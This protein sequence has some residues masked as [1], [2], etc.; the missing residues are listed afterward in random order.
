MRAWKLIEAY[1]KKGGLC[2]SEP[3]MLLYKSES[4]FLDMA[5]QLHFGLQALPVVALFGS[6]H[7]GV[8]YMHTFFTK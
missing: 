7:K 3:S 8:E 5:V 2:I 1:I 4:Q 6:V